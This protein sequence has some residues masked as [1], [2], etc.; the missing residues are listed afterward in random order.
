MY[1]SNC[2]AKF[3]HRGA[4]QRHHCV[5]LSENR[6]STLPKKQQ[7]SSA[8]VNL[9]EF[10]HKQPE[11]DSHRKITQQELEETENEKPNFASFQQ[12]FL[13]WRDSNINKSKRNQQKRGLIPLTDELSN[14]DFITSK[15][16]T[17]DKFRSK[18]QQSKPGVFVN[19]HQSF[20][21]NTEL[22]DPSIDLEV[23]IIYYIIF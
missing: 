3:H 19:I 6:L 22:N 10:Y 20:S 12:S 14:I 15:T 16:N 17:Q 2:F 8:D 9:R 11:V 13:Q 5:L 18:K 23:S 21:D 1:C 4:L 7:S